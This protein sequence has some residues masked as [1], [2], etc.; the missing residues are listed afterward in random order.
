V[1]PP[2]STTLSATALT[3][4]EIELTWPDASATETEYQLERQVGADPAESLPTQPAD[5]T[6]YVDA[7]LA[8]A[9]TYTYRVRACNA[10]GCADWSADASA[11]TP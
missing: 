5:S 7:G 10:A 8:S 11:T 3:S 6:S 1:T 4:S 2:N 9:T